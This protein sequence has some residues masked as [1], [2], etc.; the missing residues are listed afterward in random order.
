MSFK[1]NAKK[2]YSPSEYAA[3][4]KMGKVSEQDIESHF[5]NI[6][7]QGQF[8]DQQIK[9]K[10]GGIN[11]QIM[12]AAKKQANTFLD[13]DRDQAVK[14]I[15]LMVPNLLNQKQQISNLG[16]GGLT[17]DNEVSIGTRRAQ[18]Q[19]YAAAQ[20]YKAYKE[21]ILNPQLRNQLATDLFAGLGLFLSN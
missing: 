20:Q 1:L 19:G 9:I 4:L 6:K 18:D 12:D 3:L 15:N 7:A 10:E 13:I 16:S 8:A 11:S 2:V 5:N 17:A 21:Q 14:D